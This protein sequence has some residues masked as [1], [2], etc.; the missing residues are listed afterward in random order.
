VGDISPGSALYSPVFDFDFCPLSKANSG[1]SSPGIVRTGHPFPLIGVHRS[2]ERS[3]WQSLSIPE[4]GP[5]FHPPVHAFSRLPVLQSPPYEETH[6]HP[7][8]HAL[9]DHDV[10]ALFHF[11]QTANTA[12]AIDWRNDADTKSM[13]NDL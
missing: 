11:Y 8:C 9:G 1:H 6:A 2:A 13:L 10:A 3:V 12:M 4:N 7:L 5:V